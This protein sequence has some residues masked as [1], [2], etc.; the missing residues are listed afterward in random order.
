MSREELFQALMSAFGTEEAFFAAFKAFDI[1]AVA[2]ATV[3]QGHLAVLHSEKQVFVKVKKF[4]IENQMRMDFELM[5]TIAQHNET[6]TGIYE[7]L[8]QN[9]MTEMDWNQEVR[10]MEIA[11]GIY[12][13]PEIGIHVPKVLGTWPAEKADLIV[14]EKVSGEVLITF[15]PDSK[16]KACTLIR[17]LTDFYRIWWNEAMF[18]SGF[19]HADPHAGN[20]MFHW[21]AEEPENSKLWIIDYGNVKMLEEDVRASIMELAV[22]VLVGDAESIANG[23]GRR[24]Y[25]EHEQLWNELVA[26]LEVFLQSPHLIPLSIDDKISQV[27][28]HIAKQSQLPS[29]KDVVIFFRAKSLFDGLFK[30]LENEFGSEFRAFGCPVPKP[31]KLGAYVAVS[32]L[33]N[34]RISIRNAKPAI[35]KTFTTRLRQVPRIL[36]SLLGKSTV[37]NVEGSATKVAASRST[38][39]TSTITR[40]AAQQQQFRVQ[41]LVQNELSDDS[42]SSYSSEQSAESQCSDSECDCQNSKRKR[43]SGRVNY[44]GSESRSESSSSYSEEEENSHTFSIGSELYKNAQG[45]C[46]PLERESLRSSSS[47]DANSQYNL[48]FNL[49]RQTSEEDRINAFVNGSVMEEVIQ[50]NNAQ[51]AHSVLQETDHSIPQERS[52]S[53]S[54]DS[55]NELCT[56]YKFFQKI[57]SQKDESTQKQIPEPNKRQ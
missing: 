54:Q 38:V 47:I 26:G 44:S 56:S 28:K 39:I 9:L 16:E 42:Y 46:Y 17:L 2:S 51:E 52:S 13:R 43:S 45:Q 23:L 27:M 48:Q 3:A 32:S 12:H 19:M 25:P 1:K 57:A 11:R 22:G 4:G 49:Q 34:L 35:Y 41:T 33:K 15:V 55:D 36:Y 6:Y 20:V 21:D 14:M 50:P 18:D 5:S 40:N 10:N 30:R 31:N 7:I 8:Q 29:A 53:S 37:N 24:R